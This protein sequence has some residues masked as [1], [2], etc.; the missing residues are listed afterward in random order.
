MLIPLVNRTL[1]YQDSWNNKACV[2]IG[3]QFR[4]FVADLGKGCVE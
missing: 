1:P 3:T 4:L 2:E